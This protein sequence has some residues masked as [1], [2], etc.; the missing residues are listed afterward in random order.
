MSWVVGNCPGLPASHALGH[1]SQASRE[2]V[3]LGTHGKAHTVAAHAG[4]VL[5]DLQSPNAV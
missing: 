2:Q 1:C 3:N 4:A 5:N